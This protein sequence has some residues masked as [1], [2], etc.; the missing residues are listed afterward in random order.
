MSIFE[1]FEQHV[2]LTVLGMVVLVVAFVY[3]VDTLMD[4]LAR[5]PR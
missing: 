1:F 3:A 4:A 5:L 2:V